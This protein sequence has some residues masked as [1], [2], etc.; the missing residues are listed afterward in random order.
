LFQSQKDGKYYSRSGLGLAF[1]FIPYVLA[2]KV[3]ALS[4]G[5]AESRLID[6]LISFYNIFFGAGACLI[7][8]ILL[9]FSK[10]QEKH[11]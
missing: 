7:M 10:T 5:L 2:G 8:F 9:N 6:F 11:L 3:I 1:L 4:T